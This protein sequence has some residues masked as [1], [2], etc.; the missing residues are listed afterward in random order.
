MGLFFLI[1]GGALIV[2][3]LLQFVGTALVILSFLNNWSPRIHTWIVRLFFLPL[4]VQFLI[5]R[6]QYP[7]SW[8]LF[9]GLGV[10]F[11]V[12]GLLLRVYSR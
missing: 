12:L 5:S 4:G 6:R 2:L 1:F 8:F 10:F 7:L 3:G 11:L 9:W